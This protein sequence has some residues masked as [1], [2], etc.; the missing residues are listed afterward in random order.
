MENFEK[1]II[2]GETF[3]VNHKTGETMSALSKDEF[4]QM[5]VNDKIAEDKRVKIVNKKAM[6]KWNEEQRKE[7][8]KDN[9]HLKKT[10]SR[11]GN[12]TERNAYLIEFE[13]SLA[14]S[15]INTVET[16]KTTLGLDIDGQH[17]EIKVTKKNKPIASFEDA[18]GKVD[19]VKSGIFDIILKDVEEKF[20]VIKNEVFIRTDENDF[21][22]RITKKKDKLEGL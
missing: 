8:E 11:G 12:S 19:K 6:E 3:Y 13:K 14:E 20:V 17:F 2:D 7:N 15:Q 10:T 22:I 4:V 18:L 16:G 1:T 5:A 21:Q 9:Q